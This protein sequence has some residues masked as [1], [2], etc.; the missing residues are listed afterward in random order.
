[1]IGTINYEV[2][3]RI[4]SRVSHVYSERDDIVKRRGVLA[5]AGTAV[6]VGAGL[7]AQHRDQ[8]APAQRSRRRRTRSGQRRG[9]RSRTV[10]LT[11]EHRYSSRRSDPESPRA[12]AVF[13]HGSCLRTDVWHYQMPGLGGPPLVFFD[14]RGPR[15]LAA[16]RRRRLLDH[17]RWRD[18]LAAV[19][20]DC[21]SRRGRSRRPFRRRDDRAGVLLAPNLD[22]LGEGLKGLVLLQ[23]HASAGLRDADRRRRRL[24]V[25]TR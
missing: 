25:R 21:G 4:P 8:P 11:M 6:G 20:D 16:E 24:E 2:T 14:L 9:V 3:T 17:R 23:H 5:L 22:L 10:E 7:V 13:I 12:G 15:A 1:M 19:I 18:D